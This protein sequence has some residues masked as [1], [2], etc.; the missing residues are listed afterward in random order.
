MAGDF[1]DKAKPVR[2]GESLDWAKVEQFLKDSIP[3]LRGEL[4]VQQF[5]SGFSNLTYLI[6]VGETELVLRRPPFG[7]KA[8]TAHDMA[9]E[10]RILKTLK[11][12]FRYCP[13]PLAYGDDPAIMD[14]PFYVMERLRGII[15]RANPPKGLVLSVD[16]SRTLC[17]KM[18]DVWCE[19]HRIDYRAIGLADFGKPEG[20]VRRQVEG[21]S[22]RYRRART[23]D[24]PDFEL[25]MRW[26]ADR[27]PPDSAHAAIIHNDYKFDNLV[28]D[29][30]DPTRIIGVL[31]WEMSTLGDPLMDLGGGLAYWIN[32]DDPEAMQMI[33]QLSTNLPGMFTREQVVA[34]YAEKMG[35]PVERFDFYY[36]FGLFRLAVIAQQIYY[37][38]FHG[39]T[40][41]PRF[42]M[43]VYAVQVL[44]QTA[45]A[46]VEKSG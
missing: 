32:P 27:Q 1:L 13:E 29:A 30:S 28:L 34:C 6:A 42:Q 45:R 18:V 46:L 24:A 3:G 4:S 44:E 7:T 8:K 31:D 43:L 37:R 15:L 22:E 12:V 41:D 33:R 36:C 17:E 5:P 2:E 9:R 40:K 35:R 26:L 20:Y 38:F 14:V 16:Q 11:P 19:L 23:P 25:V 21:W 10:Y 39:Q